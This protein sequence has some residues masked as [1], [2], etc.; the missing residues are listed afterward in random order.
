MRFIGFLNS[1][2]VVQLL[3]H[4]WH[5]ATPRS[6]DCQASLSFTIS[7]SLLKLMFIELVMTSNY[8]VL[9]HPLLLLPS[10]FP[11]IRIFSNKLALCIRFQRIVASA[12]ELSMNIQGWFPLGLT[13]L[14]S[15]LS[16]GLSRDFSSTTIQKHQF[17]VIQLHLL[18]NS[19]IHTWLLEKP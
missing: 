4:V 13:D 19:H 14:I 3:S 2:V 17:F 6:A 5:F 11:Y 10:I 9:C 16:K 7:H 15:L 18:Y 8:L 12:L 1:N